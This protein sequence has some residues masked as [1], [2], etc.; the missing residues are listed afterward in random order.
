MLFLDHDINNAM[1][2]KLLLCTFKQLSDVKIN[3]DKS[4]IFCFVQAKHYEMQFSQLFGCK[5]ITYIPFRYLDLPMHYTKPNNNDE[6]GIEKK[7]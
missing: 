6:N 7:N 5:T 4:E 1:Y 3:F 2:M